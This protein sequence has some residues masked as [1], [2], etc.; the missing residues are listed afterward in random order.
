[1]NQPDRLITC[2]RELVL[3]IGTDYDCIL[4]NYTVIE[5]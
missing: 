3:G 4:G 2:G 5:F 1:M